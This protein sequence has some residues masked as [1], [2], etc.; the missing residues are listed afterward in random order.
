[1]GLVNLKKELGSNIMSLAEPG[2]DKIP[3]EFPAD[4]IKPNKINRLSLKDIDFID[5]K[6]LELSGR[7]SSLETVYETFN[8]DYAYL[9]VQRRI[10]RLSKDTPDKPKQVEIVKIFSKGKGVFSLRKPKPKEIE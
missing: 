9:Q 7:E 1:V 6:I 2:E 8:N 4:L 5:K 10:I 3:K